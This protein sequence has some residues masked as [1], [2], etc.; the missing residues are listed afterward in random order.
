[1]VGKHRGTPN[2]LPQGRGRAQEAAQHGQE[3]RKKT[4]NTNFFLELRDGRL[5]WHST[6]STN[7]T[8]STTTTYYYYLHPLTTIIIAAR[9]C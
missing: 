5:Y 9:G 6:S 8:T 4:S 3:E 7:T 2:L 1:M